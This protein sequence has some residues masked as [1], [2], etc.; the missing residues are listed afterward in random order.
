MK[1]QVHHVFPPKPTLFYSLIQL[2]SITPHFGWA[3]RISNFN[4]SI[5]SHPPDPSL[6]YGDKTIGSDLYK[7]LKKFLNNKTF[8]TCGAIVVILVKRYPNESN[9]SDIIYQLRSNHI[10][11]YITVDS[12]PSGGSNSATLFEMSSKTNGYCVFASDYDLIFAF[13]SMGAILYTPYQFVAQNFVV[14]GSGRIELPVFKTPIHEGWVQWTRVVITV[15]DHTLDNS[16]V[17]VNY[18][19]SSTDGVVAYKFPSD[20]DDQRHGTGQADLVASNGTLHYKWTID[21]QYST[22]TPQIIE[23]RMYSY[24]YHDF[25]PLPDF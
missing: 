11:V 7:V 19:I 13:Q 21:Y 4:A 23:C 12:I 1:I 17:S 6:G 15:Q 9:V 18:T 2:T 25:L 16:F 5:F 24:S 20:H 22:N 8:S 3:H 14:T 10:L